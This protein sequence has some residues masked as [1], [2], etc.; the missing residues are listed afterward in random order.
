MQ[1]KIDHMTNKANLDDILDQLRVEYIETSQEKLDGVDNLISKL[2]KNVN[3]E[4]RNTYI[5]FQRE[6]H[7]I[8]GTAGSYG[9]KAVTEIAHSLENYLETSNNLGT[10]QLSDVQHYIDKM[11]WIFES[12]KNPSDEVTSE[13][14]RSLPSPNKPSFSTQQVRD[15]PVILV[16]PYNIQ[17]KI[18]ASELA[19]CGFRVAIADNGVRAIELAFTHRP[20][21]MFS[22]IDVPDISGVELAIIFRS[23]EATKKVNIALLSSQPASSQ[24]FSNLPEDVKLIR[25]GEEFSEDLAECLIGWQVFIKEARRSQAR[26]ERSHLRISYDGNV[27]ISKNGKDFSGQTIDISAGGLSI[28]F[29]ADEKEEALPIEHGDRITVDVEGLSALSGSVIRISK[30]NVFVRF[31]LDQ[32]LEDKLLAEI[33]LATNGIEPASNNG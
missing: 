27:I 19:S 33:M 18:I 15:I 26:N 10:D 16:M 6:V 21:I 4:W 8:K 23:I 7:S 32:S 31:D 5:E 30:N 14:L 28:D 24:I 22:N 20:L 2:A 17:R 25:K 9:F 11:R 1:S 13:I 12:G 29:G 3:E